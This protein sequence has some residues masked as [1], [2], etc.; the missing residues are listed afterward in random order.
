MNAR[1]SAA[2]CYLGILAAAVA[3]APKSSTPKPWVLRF[4]GAGPVKV[5]MS[6]AQLNTALNENFSM[7]EDEDEKACFFAESAKYP[8]IAFMVQSGRVTRVDVIKPNIAT[9]SGIRVGDSEALVMKVY[10][11]KLKVEPHAYTGP[12]GHY[13]TVY[14]PDGRYGLR[15]E[16]DGQKVTGFYAGERHAIAYVEGCL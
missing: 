1:T 13:L 4:D 16:T 7:P 15:F 8:G 9:A 14:S 2:V 11:Q 6:L 12:E 5:G 3:A 10:G